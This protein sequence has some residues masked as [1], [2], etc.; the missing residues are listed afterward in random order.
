[1][2]VTLMNINYQSFN[3]FMLRIG[4]LGNKGLPIPPSL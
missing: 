4:K 3:N 2:K 1:M